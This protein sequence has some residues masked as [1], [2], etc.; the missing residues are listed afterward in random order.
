MGYAQS[1]P[2]NSPRMRPALKRRS[3]AGSRRTTPAKRG[4]L[5][6]RIQPGQQERRVGDARQNAFDTGMVGD[7]QTSYSAGTCPRHQGSN[8]H[9]PVD[10]PLWWRSQ[11][12]G[13]K[14]GR[15]TVGP[16]TFPVLLHL[17]GM[18]RWCS[19]ANSISHRP[20][21]GGW[22]GRPARPDI[23]DASGRYRRFAGTVPV[24]TVLACSTNQ[25]AFHRVRGPIASY[26]CGSIAG[27]F[28]PAESTRPIVRAE[29]GSGRLPLG[30]GRLAGGLADLRIPRR[31]A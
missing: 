3:D 1:A 11:L 14:P 27:R 12:T 6:V 22:M 31:A 5:L 24:T 10:A 7:T 26:C 17:V 18:A 29:L 19:L 16:A 8:A 28:V 9:F 21:P 13:R 20:H 25:R 30:K 2:E 23:P 4:G 15:P